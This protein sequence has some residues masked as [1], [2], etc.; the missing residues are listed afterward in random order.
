MYFYVHQIVHRLKMATNPLPTNRMPQIKVMLYTSKIL[1]D[2]SHPLRLRITK[3]N[4]RKYISIGESCSLKYW[5]TDKE[6]PRRNH[7]ERT[8][9]LSVIRKW[10]SEYIEA[11]RRL[12]DSGHPFTIDMLIEAVVE[13]SKKPRRERKGMMLL[14]YLKTISEQLKV[15]KKLGN[16]NVYRDTRSALNRFLSEKDIP[17]TAVNVS[18]LNRFE[19][20]LRAEDCADTSLS[21]YFRTLRAAI[22]K[23]ISENLFPADLYPF[24][25]NRSEKHK[26]SISKFD[27]STRKRAISKEE[28]RRIEAL[29]VDTP[30]L[31]LAKHL[32]LFSYFGGG[33]NFVDMTQL[34][35]RNVQGGRLQYVR[36]KTGGIFNLKLAPQALAILEHYRALT[37]TSQDAYIFTVLHKDRHKTLQQIDNRLHKVNREVNSSLKEIGKLAGIE[38]PLTTYVARHSFATALKHSGV[39]TAVISEAMGH[40]TEAI[41][42]TYLA[43]FEND[44]IDEAFNNL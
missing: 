32:F 23:A 16:A 22:N 2:G 40:K 41:T 42:Q 14:D 37:E 13:S 19:T 9:I 21:V 10:E 26:F 36:Q 31:L 27:T 30:K 25:R 1:A 15:A 6:E 8:R 17:I 38:V 43:S 33:I 7:P 29:E 35:W 24:T 39:S 28:L 12:H 5:D 4:G 44:L 20:Y 18:F 3:D 11:A 34:T